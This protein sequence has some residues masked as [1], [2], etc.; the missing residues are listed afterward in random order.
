QETAEVAGHLR[1]V[2]I[3][4]L[5]TRLQPADRRRIALVGMVEDTA[6]AEGGA[7]QARRHP[8]PVGETALQGAV[9]GWCARRR[10]LLTLRRLDLGA[11]QGIKAPAVAA[12]LRLQ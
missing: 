10:D 6:E 12:T 9:F 11:D 7:Q 5:K 2:E 1:L 8:D 4:G 3:A